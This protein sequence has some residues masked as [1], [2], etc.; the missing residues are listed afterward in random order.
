MSHPMRVFL[1]KNM[2]TYALDFESYYDK[3]CSIK[4]L[5][6]L[7]Y[8]SHPDFDAYLVSVVGDN[9]YKFVGPPKDLDWARLNGNRIISHN[10]SF[11]E[12]LYLYGVQQ[13]WWP[14]IEPAEWHCTADLVAYLGL[15]RSLK[16]ASADVFGI[17]VDKTTRDNMSGKRWE[18]M[19]ED[20]QKEVMEYALQDS[21]LCLRLWQDLGPKWPDSEKKL[22]F[23]NRKAVQR[24]IPMD[25]ELLQ[26]QLD[27][28]KTRLFEAEEIIPWAGERPLLS[29]PAFD[30]HCRACGIEPPESLAEG[31]VD[32]Q[33]W[34]RIHGA[35]YK[36]VEA[37]KNWRRINALKKKLESFDFATMPDG[38]YYGGVMYFGAHTGRFTGSGGNLNLQN[39]PRDEMFGVN[40]RHLIAPKPNRR[41]I[42]ADLSQIE[43]RTTCWLAGD[44][45]ALKDIAESDDIYETFAIRFGMWDKSKGS[46]RQDP[47]L[48]HKVKSIVLGCG[49]GV[50]AEKFAMISGMDLKEAEE[51]VELYRTSMK[52]VKQLWSSY[53]TD[54]SGSYDA[55]C[56]F[57]VELPSSRKL[58]YGKLRLAR[59]NN[60]NQYVALIQKNGKRLPVKL[61]GGLITEN[62]SQALARDIFGDILCRIHDAG[63]DLIMHIHDEAVIEVDADVAEEK[64]QEVLKIMSTPPDWIPDIP[65]AAEGKILT[66]FEK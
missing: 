41:L 48:R 11:D 13:G 26:T 37:V 49:Y 61:W 8:F 60:R 66:K 65:I 24:G 18:Q 44:K 64:L 34:L 56:D 28:L 12:T 38:R 31:D 3:S 16:G 25:A 15:P 51:S 4:Q 14:T 45:Q 17:A 30:D 59:Q 10:A 63:M 43:V 5:G 47:R 6:P 40:L 1:F 29:R 36:W 2:E 58:N 53:N 23:V 35:K 32:A 50:G 57:T 62:T 19:T 54:I 21:E 22:S 9:G 39:L 20:F 27:T 52:K 55:R 33:E 7:G 42:V 46:I